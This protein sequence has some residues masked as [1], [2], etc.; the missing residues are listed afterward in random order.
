[1]KNLSHQV[2]MSLYSTN[3]EEVIEQILLYLLYDVIN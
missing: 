2:F 3:N 1:M